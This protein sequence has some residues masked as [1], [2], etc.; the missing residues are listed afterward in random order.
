[1][2]RRAILFLGS[3]ATAGSGIRKDG[4]CL[5]TDSGFFDSPLVTNGLAVGYPALKLARRQLLH[6]PKSSLYETWNDLFILRGFAWAEVVPVGSAEALWEQLRKHCWKPDFDYRKTHYDLQSKIRDVDLSRDHQRRPRPT[7]YYLAE[8]AI[9]DLRAILADVYEVSADDR[10][11]R[12]F[13]GPIG[14]RLST[15]V[16]LNYDSTFDDCLGGEFRPLFREALKMNGNEPLLMI[17]PHG[18]LKWTTKNTFCLGNLNWCARWEPD[19]SR[20]SKKDLGYRQGAD[21]HVFHFQQPHIVAPPT[22]KEE[23]VGTSSAEGLQDPVLRCQWRTLAER[24][25]A[26]NCWIFVGLSLS[27]GDDHLLHLLRRLYTPEIRLHCSCYGTDHACERLDRIFGPHAGVCSHGIRP[28]MTIDT[29][30][31]NTRCDL[32]PHQRARP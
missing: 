25:K 19:E 21:A 12:S 24:A 20:T 27:S 29:F 30:W 28:G 5:P 14:G 17:R 4:H 23:V 26:A 10:V 18:S 2:K 11:Y 16:N 31:E 3:G 6:E 32:I 8:L 15:V 22:F 1:M 7:A 13:W 9:W